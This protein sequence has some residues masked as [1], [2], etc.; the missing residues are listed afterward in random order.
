MDAKLKSQS[1]KASPISPA[2]G[3]PCY[4]AQREFVEI[5]GNYRRK[6]I[7][8]P[9]NEAR[10]TISIKRLYPCSACFS[11]DVASSTTARAVGDLRTA[12]SIT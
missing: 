1:T 11:R 4:T 3:V 7:F 10:F 2:E 5:D 9:N 6:Y 12:S 8:G